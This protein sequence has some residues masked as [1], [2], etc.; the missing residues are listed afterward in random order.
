LDAEIISDD[1]DDFITS[2]NISEDDDDIVQMNDQSMDLEDDLIIFN[3]ELYS[4]PNENLK[5]E[6]IE[7]VNVSFS[8][9]EG[10]DDPDQEIVVLSD[11]LP[12]QTTTNG[13]S[14]DEDGFEF[15]F[16]EE[17]MM[18]VEEEDKISNMLK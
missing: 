12:S 3:D 18:E 1:D 6:P 17:D 10:D 4:D 2:T 16:N 13:A 7:D 11:N 9:S 14:D 8:F 5:H 15:N